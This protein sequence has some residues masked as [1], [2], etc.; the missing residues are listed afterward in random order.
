[1]GS[2]TLALPH[3]SS[4]GLNGRE[5]FEE[6]T[7]CAGPIQRRVRGCATEGR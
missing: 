1:M 6:A 7:V 2:P 3:S 5:S 4:L